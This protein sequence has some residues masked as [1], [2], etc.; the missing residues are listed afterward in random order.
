MEFFK[1][2]DSLLKDFAFQWEEGIVKIHVLSND[3]LENLKMENIKK[4]EIPRNYPW[5]KSNLIN[6]ISYSSPFLKIEMQSGDII[7]IEGDL[8]E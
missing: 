5:G 2:H 6:E 7:Q 3:G 8:I 1:Y 4:I